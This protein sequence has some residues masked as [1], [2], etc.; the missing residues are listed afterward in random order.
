MDSV[1]TLTPRAKIKGDMACFIV[2][3]DIVKYIKGMVHG[4]TIF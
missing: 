1:A 4:D 3:L 2:L